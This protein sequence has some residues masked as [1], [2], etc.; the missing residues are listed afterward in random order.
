M[1]RPSLMTVLLLAALPV[2]LDPYRAEQHPTTAEK[3][4]PRLQTN[5]GS[6]HETITVREVASPIVIG[7]QDG[8]RQGG[9]RWLALG[10][11]N[12]SLFHIDP[13]RLRRYL[14]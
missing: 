6:K 3:R 2:S 7:L 12:A 1:R 11:K 4:R 14:Q 9:I 13:Q 8:A 5:P 10:E